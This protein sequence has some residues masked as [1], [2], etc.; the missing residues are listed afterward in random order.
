MIE[1]LR[2]VPNNLHSPILAQFNSQIETEHIAN[3]ITLNW[4]LGFTFVKMYYFDS[5]ASI[6]YFIW[7][8]VNIYE[9]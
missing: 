9:S 6:I 3:S 1:L 5:N 2:R 8:V 7:C 4:T